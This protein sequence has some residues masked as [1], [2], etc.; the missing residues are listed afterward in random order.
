MSCYTKWF[1]QPLLYPI[2]EIDEYLPFFSKFDK[3]KLFKHKFDKIVNYSFNFQN[4]KLIKII[5]KNDPLNKEKNRIKCCLIKKNYHVKGEI[6]IISRPI[7][8]CL[9]KKNYHVKGEIII[10]SR[11]KDLNNQ[12]DILFCSSDNL[13]EFS[14]NKDLNKNSS[15]KKQTINDVICYGAS[16]PC[17]KKDFN[18]RIMIKSKYIKFILIRNYYRK[19]SALEIFTYKPNKSYYFNF[20]ENIVFKKYD[21]NIVLKV[22]NENEKFKKL[23]FNKEIILFYNKNYESNIFP[24]YLDTWEKKLL[25]YNTKNQNYFKNIHVIKILITEW[26]TPSPGTPLS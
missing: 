7:K 25:F 10:I 16:F 24:L 8:C 21:N 20:K 1:Q 23:I 26:G 14:C 13:K 15:G 2:L 4:N 5:K 9:I 18:R 12:F 6:I 3:K 19:T 17:L 22:I 11:P